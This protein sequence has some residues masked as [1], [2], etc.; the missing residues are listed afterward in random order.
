MREAPNHLVDNEFIHRG[1]RIGFTNPYSILKS[2]FSVHNESVNVW[3]HLLGSVFVAIMIIF[4]A[5]QYSAKN[6][7]LEY[8]ETTILDAEHNVTTIL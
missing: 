4:V 7:A 3:S 1:Y 8:H 6:A 5:F 2:L